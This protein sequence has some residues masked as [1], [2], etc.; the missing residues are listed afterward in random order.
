MSA[1]PTDLRNKL[2]K[3]VTTARNLAEKAAKAALETLAV[4][5][6]EPYGHMTVEQRKLRNQL[7][8]RARQAGD[9][10][11]GKGVLSI[12][13]LAH[14]CAYEHWHRMLFAR[15]LAENNLLIEPDS[16]V[17][18]SLDEC[19]ELAKAEKTDLWTLAGRYAQKM[20][21]EVFRAD[22]P[23]L[24]VTLAREDQLKLDQLLDG[25][26]AATFTAGDSLGWCYQFWQSERKD[27]DGK[28][29]GEI[30]AEIAKKAAAESGA[31]PVGKA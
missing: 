13:H 9:V 20:L 6:H 30:E 26:S 2:E 15:F 29:L 28:T 22:D 8:A 12:K 1:L 7:R 5:H 4:H 16:G 23:L 10:Q 31:T 17:A 11:D 3:A 24:Q 27:E 19:K 14:E 25:L 18:I 21:P